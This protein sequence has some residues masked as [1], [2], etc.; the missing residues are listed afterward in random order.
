MKTLVI[1][2][3]ATPHYRKK[4]FQYIK[5]N[6]GKNFIL[7]SGTSYFE[8]SIKTDK[9]IVFLKPIHNHYFFN[10]RFLFQNGMWHGSLIC[11]V[12]VLELNPRIISNWFLLVARIL[13]FKKTVLWGHVW[14]RK[15]KNSKSEIIRHCMRILATEI[16]VYTKTQQNELQEKMPKKKI[17]TASNAIFY[18]NEMQVTEMKNEEIN[19]L[20]YVGRLSKSK[21]PKLLIEAF[22]AVLNQLP[23]KTQLLI[24]G[25]GEE[26][27]AINE[28]IIK[29]NLED[30]IKILDQINDFSIL[31]KLYSTSL[32]S[33]SPGYVGL[34]ITQS[35]AFGVPMLISKDENHSPEI[36]AATENENC[37]F[38]ETD[39]IDD[40]S[41]KIFEFFTF[42]KE[43]LLKRNNISI[44]CKTNYSIENM[45]NIFID[46]VK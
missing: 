31:K 4:V 36:E 28:L 26:K 8:D 39:S 18:K 19:D 27:D 17:T 37:L 21:K 11:D 42:K 6:L 1:L 2:Q 45:S 15:G 5:N 7:Y 20:I 43:W 38:F 30:R 25:D 40:L 22:I 41:T 35:F 14:P 33:V 13:L 9:E 3:T 32:L 46:L 44:F 34:S 10:R 29:N 23:K 12:L 16:I 24:I